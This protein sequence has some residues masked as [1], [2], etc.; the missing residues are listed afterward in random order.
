MI[1][2]PY[3]PNLSNELF[4][5]KYEGKF[6]TISDIRIINMVLTSYIRSFTPE[7]VKVS[8]SEKTLHWLNGDNNIS[9]KYYNLYNTDGP[10]NST[11]INDIL[12]KYGICISNE[13]IIG[14]LETAFPNCNIKYVHKGNTIKYWERGYHE[15]RLMREKISTRSEE[16]VNQ[17]LVFKNKNEKH[18]TDEDIIKLLQVEFPDYYFKVEY[19][20]DICIDWSHQIHN[21]FIDDEIV[22]LQ[23]HIMELYKQENSEE[24][25][26]ELQ[27]RIMKLYAEKGKN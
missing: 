4:K 11:I 14:C 21:K 27:E 9:T 24:K 16:L 18:N 7:L 3:L 26:A 23:E 10:N 15:D 19:H 17:A 2:Q 25:I 8:H 12:K 5:D 20:H 13:D 22:K 1:S 6:Y